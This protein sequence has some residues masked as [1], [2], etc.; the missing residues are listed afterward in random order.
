MMKAMMKIF[1]VGLILCAIAGSAWAQGN[2]P[3]GLTGLWQFAHQANPLVAT[4]GTDLQSTFANPSSSYFTGSTTHIGTLLN[5]D[6]YSDNGV[7][8]ELQYNYLTVT[9]NIPANGGGAYVN[10]YTFAV[11]YWQTGGFALWNGN[12]YNSLFQTWE[13]NTNDGDLFIRT[14]AIPDP[15]YGTTGHPD[16]MMPDMAH[17]VI[18]NGDMGYSTLTFDPSQGHRIVWSVDAAN[19]IDIY[20]DG[21]QYLH[22]TTADLGLDGRYALDPTCLLF[23][24]NDGEDAWGLVATAAVWDHALTSA[25]VAAMGSPSTPLIIG[26]PEP[27]TF[28]LLA[29]GLAGLFFVRKK[30]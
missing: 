14:P 24:D 15:L 18:G 29:I 27:S 22:D 30:K 10:Q 1:V 25:E 13:G 11:D 21:A 19:A 4:V 17:S 3:A 2:V 9:H 28:V 26:V 12:Y 8:Q 7:L 16:P 20:V 6:A 5:P 23:G